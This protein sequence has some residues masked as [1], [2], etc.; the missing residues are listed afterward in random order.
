MKAKEIPVS[1]HQQE[2]PDKTKEKEVQKA[3]TPA[4]ESP[5]EPTPKEEVEPQ[6]PRTSNM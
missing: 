5:A 3:V 2:Y 1:V 4:V 6:A